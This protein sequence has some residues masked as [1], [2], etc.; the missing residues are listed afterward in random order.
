ME[1]N[2][3]YF[4]YS[5]THTHILFI[6]LSFLTYFSLLGFSKKK[7]L[8]WNLNLPVILFIVFVVQESYQH[9]GNR[10]K[11]T[12]SLKWNFKYLVKL[13]LLP[14][15]FTWVP[16]LTHD[17]RWSRKCRNHHGE[18]CPPTR[19]IKVSPNIMAFNFMKNTLR[20]FRMLFLLHAPIWTMNVSV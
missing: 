16:Y 17:L 20:L 6:L 7:F 1:L 19:S 13:W 8:I 5:C 12:I 15:T 18:K 10:T 4:V 14:V 11:E 3:V 2:G 9:S